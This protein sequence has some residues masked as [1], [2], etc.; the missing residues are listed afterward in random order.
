MNHSHKFEPDKR[1]SAMDLVLDYILGTEDTVSVYDQFPDL[2]FESLKQELASRAAS[3]T[4]KERTQLNFDL[5][6]CRDLHY[7]VATSRHCLILGQ[8]NNLRELYEVYR[9]MLPSTK[10][11]EAE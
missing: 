4:L 8:V 10:P 5:A 3:A 7:G 9:L 2:T 1:K 11:A 6:L